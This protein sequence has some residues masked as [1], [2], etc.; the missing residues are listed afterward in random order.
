MPH[1][2]RALR[3][4]SP[5]PAPA[6]ADRLTCSGVAC[7]GVSWLR[8]LKV[9][10][11]Q[12]IEQFASRYPQ[13]IDANTQAKKAAKPAKVFRQG[14]R[15]SRRVRGEEAAA[16]AD[17]ESS[18]SEDDEEDGE[19]QKQDGAK[20]AGG[21]DD[22]AEGDGSAAEAEEDAAAAAE[23]AAADAEEAASLASIG[24]AEDEIDERNPL[25]SKSYYDL[26]AS[27]RLVVLK[28]LCD[29]QLET[30]EDAAEGNDR[31][32]RDIRLFGDGKLAPEDLRIEPFSD[33]RDENLFWYFDCGCRVYREMRGTAS[34]RTASRRGAARLVTLPA[35]KWEA[36]A[37]SIDE[38]DA[39]L[40][41]LNKKK[42]KSEADLRKK[43]QEILDDWREN[44][45]SR[46]RA[47]A[48][49]ERTDL[50]MLNVKRSSRVQLLEQKQKEEQAKEEQAARI[51]E[52]RRE[53]LAERKAQK[54]RLQL[55][56]ERAG[57]AA[58]AGEDVDM[59][60]L[61]PEVREEIEAREAEKAAELSQRT[62]RQRQKERER[63]EKEEQQ[64]IPPIG[65]EGLNRRPPRGLA[66]CF[67]ALGSGL[68]LVGTVSARR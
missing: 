16:D 31:D 22:D 40:T 45:A 2:P 59:A 63:R 32:Y 43:L 67:L 23:K 35:L 9:T 65:A 36:V 26:P 12:R 47:R 3:P 50:A 68:G 10:L 55:Q 49:Q 29:W 7:S 11:Y 44:F 58:L 8:S 62:E 48:K 42:H 1:A 54:L 21:D 28:A 61:S 27:T 38:L 30:H 66:G 64:V 57:Q 56:M 13:V 39:F 33:D 41:K 53:E 17:D 46:E 4:P 60:L 24:L 25:H 19:S 15:T 34:P 52:V 18:E 6:A 5:Q 14:S 51:A 20:S 37:C